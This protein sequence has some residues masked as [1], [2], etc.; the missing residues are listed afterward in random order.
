MA[1]P[2]PPRLRLVPA[3]AAAL[4]LACAAPAAAQ[5]AAPAF[6]TAASF[7]K[8]RAILGGTSQLQL[9]AARQA[10]LAAPAPAEAALPEPVAALA[11]AAPLSPV[12]PVSPDSPDVFGSTALAV[13]HTRLDARWRRAATPLAGGHRAVWRPLVSDLRS[14]ARLDQIERVNLWVNDRVAFTDDSDRQGRSD[15]WSRASDT[16]ARGRGDCEDYA[17]AKMQLLRALGFADEDLYLTLVRDL[18][19]RADHAVLVVR[20]E[21]R[22]LVLDNSTDALLDA[23]EVRDYRPVFSFAA[24]GAW[25]HGYRQEIELA[26]RGRGGGSLAGN[27]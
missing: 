7:A 24:S 4:L 13:A 11:A 3:A 22:F 16:L 14:A 12:P 1:L 19:R 26:A 17:I 9:I 18:V 10:G 27:R 8:S 20:H 21:G 6:P 25:L 15:R 23:G 2:A 5:D